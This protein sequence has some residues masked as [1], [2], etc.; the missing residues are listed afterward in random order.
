MQNG[1]EYY[2]ACKV[3][4]SLSWGNSF[5]MFVVIVVAVAA[6]VHVVVVVWFK[7]LITLS[8]IH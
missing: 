8:F 1:E 7:A 5:K 3:N 6:V 4:P 2:G